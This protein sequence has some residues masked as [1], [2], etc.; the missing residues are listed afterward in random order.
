METRPGLLS[1][2]NLL[3]L[4]TRQ[5]P[6]PELGD[7]PTASEFRPGPGLAQVLA[8]CRWSH[9]CMV[10]EVIN[11]LFNYLAAVHE[12]APTLQ[13]QLNRMGIS[14]PLRKVICLPPPSVLTYGKGR[15]WAVDIRQPCLNLT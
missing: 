15:L 14:P 12:Q 1:H 3:G 11:Q 8:N 10:L 7:L 13:A 6:G 4:D 9:N 2:L 5:T